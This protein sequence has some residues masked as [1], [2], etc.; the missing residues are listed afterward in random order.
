VQGKGKVVR[1]HQQQNFRSISI[2]FPAG[3]VDGIQIGASVAINGTCLTVAAL[4]L[5]P[6][7]SS[8][9]SEICL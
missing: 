3:S 1:V 5:G 7:L 4:T 9:S 6:P 8:F 2:S